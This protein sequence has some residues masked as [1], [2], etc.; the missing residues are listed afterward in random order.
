MDI[1][2][3]KV[4]NFLA[5]YGKLGMRWGKRSSS[6][7]SKDSGEKPKTSSDHD[8]SRV[9]K[10]KP[11]SSMS[12]AELKAY[13]TRMGL[14]KQY[15]ALNPSQLARGKARLDT[16]LMVGKSV[17]SA[18]EFMNSP[19]GTKIKKAIADQRTVSAAN[20]VANAASKATT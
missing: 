5:H 3:D 2:M 19:A 12:N 8:E 10:R 4:T 15:H 17:N 18:I 11:L 9:I 13:T 7:N 1:K 6:R 14:E 16:V 20:A